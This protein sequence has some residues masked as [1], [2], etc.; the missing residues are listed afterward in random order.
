MY[1]VHAL[2]YA[3]QDVPA[4]EFFYREAS[5]EPVRLDFFI[6][7][8]TG[9]PTPIVVDTGF[10][11]ADAVA[12]SM[13]NYVPPAEMV[14]RAGVDPAEVGLA[15]ITHL[16]WDHWGGHRQFPNARYVIQGREIAFFTGR[17][18]SSPAFRTEI[19]VEEL[20]DVVPLAYADRLQIIEGDHNLLPGI[21]LHLIGGHTEGTQVVS[22]DS[23]SGPVMLT[24]D[25]SHFYRNIELGRPAQIA[26]NMNAMLAGFDRITE[27]A[28]PSGRI[29]VGHDPEVFERFKE[30]DAGI[31]ELG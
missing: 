28:G 4:C 10:N 16:H 11:Q 20:A 9:G 17:F 15:V 12:R 19:N 5:H 24:S 30:V 25:A 31:V 7:L 27:L 8:I 26:S 3:D 29:V 14:R 13:R 2:K 22:V 18:G 21:D 23:G 6:W 1:S